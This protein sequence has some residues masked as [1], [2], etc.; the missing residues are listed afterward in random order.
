MFLEFILKFCFSPLVA[1]WLLFYFV[2]IPLFAFLLNDFVHSVFEGPTLIKFIIINNQ[3]GIDYVGK[4]DI[5]NVLKGKMFQFH[6][7][8]VFT[9]RVFKT[10]WTVQAFLSGELH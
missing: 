9:L 1:L 4:K 6:F 8:L 3:F 7:F 5:N 10:L 2:C